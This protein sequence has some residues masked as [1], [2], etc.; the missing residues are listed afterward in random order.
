MMNSCSVSFAAIVV[1]LVAAC[2]A[3][4]TPTT[5]NT[6]TSSTTV[7]DR[8]APNTPQTQKTQSLLSSLVR[9]S[10]IAAEN[11][12][13]TPG[14]RVNFDHDSGQANVDSIRQRL[15]R[16]P[17]EEML[18]PSV[19]SD[20]WRENDSLDDTEE[21]KERLRFG[22]PEALRSMSWDE[23]SALWHATGHESESSLL[24]IQDVTNV[25]GNTGAAST[26]SRNNRNRATHNLELL[27]KL[28]DRYRNSPMKRGDG[29]QLSVVSPLD[30]LR[31]QLL[32]EMA[33]RRMK[34]RQEKIRAN[35]A[36]IQQVGKRS[37][38][39]NDSGFD[40]EQ[41]MIGERS[42][43]GDDDLNRE[44]TVRSA[45]RLSSFLR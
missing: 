13:W 2:C 21:L 10:Q 36:F 8:Q 15:R 24:G 39:P 26:K 19:T 16:A 18:E 38:D 11:R 17:R 30:V 12:L 45:N 33:R 9:R 34:E 28:V 41:A 22:G 6:I 4:T 3:L 32:Y 31:Q 5:K 7:S 1:L 35:E 27:A 44:R 37:V 42:D 23:L 20:S 25:G 40:M 14:S 29:P 43:F